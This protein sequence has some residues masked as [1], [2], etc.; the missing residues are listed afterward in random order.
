MIMEVRFRIDKHT[1]VFNRVGTGYNNNNSVTF[2]RSKKPPLTKDMK[3]VNE[4]KHDY[5]NQLV[6][7]YNQVPLLHHNQS[8]KSIIIKPPLHKTP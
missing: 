7:T 5:N 4:V 6:N 1:Q 3:H 8:Y 2:H